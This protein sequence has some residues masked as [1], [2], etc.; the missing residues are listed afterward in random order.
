[1]RRDGTYNIWIIPK[2]GYDYEIYGE[3]TVL[4]SMSMLLGI[5]MVFG[6]EEIY[7]TKAD[8]NNNGGIYHR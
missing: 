3:I 4:L 6:I 2:T 8:E 7:E 5:K 1:L